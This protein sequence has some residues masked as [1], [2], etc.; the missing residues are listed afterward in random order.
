VLIAFHPSCAQ[1]CAARKEQCKGHAKRINEAFSMACIV[2]PVA[3]EQRRHFFDGAGL[4]A[5]TA[6]RYCF[7]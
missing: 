1:R 5:A 6:R 2:M 7:P 3:V 4:S